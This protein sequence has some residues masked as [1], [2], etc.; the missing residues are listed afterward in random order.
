ML[1]AKEQFIYL[2]KWRKNNPEKSRAKSAVANHTRSGKIVKM[3]QCSQCGRQN[4]RIEAHHDDYNKPL[5]VR[6]LC[7]SCHRLFHSQLKNERR[8]SWQ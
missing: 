7:V 2:K 5:K 1:S 8:T 6:W 4:R 3:N